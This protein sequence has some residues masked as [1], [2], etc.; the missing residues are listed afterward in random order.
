[1]NGF[2]DLYRNGSW[3][4]SSGCDAPVLTWAAS[5]SLG[6]APAFAIG[7]IKTRVGAELFL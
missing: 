5:Q 2:C 6:A 1:M 4:G 7:T 3:F